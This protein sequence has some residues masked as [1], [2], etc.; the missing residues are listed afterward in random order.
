MI[1]LHLFNCRQRTTRAG[2]SHPHLIVTAI[3]WMW[4]WSAFAP[5]RGPTTRYR[6]FPCQHPK[7]SYRLVPSGS[8]ALSIF[9][10]ISY[11]VPEPGTPGLLVAR[12]VAAS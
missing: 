5:R 1:P 6:Y 10:R 11:S 12:L 3:G 7:R 4:H 2:R 9:H 8:G